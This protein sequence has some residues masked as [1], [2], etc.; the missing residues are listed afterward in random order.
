M[1]KSRNQILLAAIIIAVIM[2][3]IPSSAQNF[4][5]IGAMG[6]GIAG[7]LI[8]RGNYI[9]AAAGNT[10]LIVIDI[11]DPHTPAIVG[12][13]TGVTS[14]AVGLSVYNNVAALSCLRQ[15][16]TVDISNPI[17]P[18]FLDSMSYISS[19]E[20]FEGDVYIY[21]GYAY[22]AVP[23]NV[24][25]SSG[26][27]IE[28][29]SNP[30][31]IHYSGYFDQTAS[32]LFTFYPSANYLFCYTV[33][34]D[35]RNLEICDLTN[36][37]LPHVV[38]L[39]GPSDLTFGIYK[40]SNY[41]YFLKEWGFKVIDITNLS[42][43]F[44]SYN[45][46]TG[47]ETYNAMFRR[48]HLCVTDNFVY[49]VGGDN[50]LRAYDLADPLHPM[51][52]G[53][54]NTAGVIGIYSRN[55]TLFLTSTDSLR[56]YRMLP[57]TSAISGMVR[58]ASSLASIPGVE[59]QLGPSGRLDTTDASGYY[60]FNRLYSSSSYNLNY[61]H[62][63]Y[64]PLA[65]SYITVRPNQSR[66]HDVILQHR[67]YKDVGVASL[68]NPAW[69][70]A[71]GANREII[72]IVTNFGTA[73]QSF[74]LRCD[75]YYRDGTTPIDSASVFVANLPARESDTLDMVIALPASDDT[76]YTIV[77]YTILNGDEIKTND[78]CTVFPFPE[79][80]G[81][82]VFYFGNQDG[83]PLVGEIGKHMTIDLYCTGKPGMSIYAVYAGLGAP[84]S[85][86]D[87]FVSINSYGPT[88]VWSD[89][90]YDTR[91]NDS[92]WALACLFGGDEMG[93]TFSSSQQPL[94]IAEYIGVINND[95]S[96]M[97]STSY[98]L[99]RDCNTSE[100]GVYSNPSVFHS[101]TAYFSPIHIAGTPQNCDYL[102]GDINNDGHVGGADV[103]YGVRY[104]K[105]YGP[106]PSDSCWDNFDVR[107]V[108]SAGD[109]N[110]NC[111]FKGSDISRLV[112]YFKSTAAIQYCPYTPPG[113]YR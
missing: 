3:V 97:D 27:E 62:P 103:T 53:M 37:I 82:V 69:Y 4:E 105:G 110:G 107:W 113:S 106:A 57:G 111:D 26:M 28:D 71:N 58:D 81:D 8:I 32:G 96:I 104:F 25:R 91:S 101:A 13:F 39:F 7:D 93:S 44:E 75:I 72:P 31:D 67:P 6:P 55:D 76:L 61:M 102:L 5:R 34:N 48:H 73:G 40:N 63:D 2:A 9:Y 1:N 47:S 45:Y 10:G 17:N 52:A 54:M 65:D 41:I 51:Y 18:V 60:E 74:T 14:S 49:R 98:C 78:T 108:Y 42:H 95:S 100:Y 11:T 46:N 30:A 15:I 89:F 79:N 29:I 90:Y 85:Y 23:N 112:A 16:I 22:V 94:K 35:N 24:T 19:G 59:V 70:L 56:I 68:S 50:T 88:S 87:T 80:H 92:G 84:N 99:R 86:I 64:Y 33:T 20:C 109:V 12:S 77:V 21:N 43:P 83:S 38:G 36:P 66:D